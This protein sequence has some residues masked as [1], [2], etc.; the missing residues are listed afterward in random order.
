MLVD[1]YES[2]EGGGKGTKMQKIYTSGT[3]DLLLATKA[4][5]YLPNLLSLGPGKARRGV[6]YMEDVRCVGEPAIDEG[7]LFLSFFLSFFLCLHSYI[8]IST[9]RHS[10]AKQSRIFGRELLSRQ[11]LR[12]TTE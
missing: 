12:G 3:Q 1:N 10:N 6:E 7:V 9:A 4:I 8:Y 2:K 11:R 5:P